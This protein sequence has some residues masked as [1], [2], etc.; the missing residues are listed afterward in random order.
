MPEKQKGQSLGIPAEG[1]ELR[2][3]GFA[4]DRERWTF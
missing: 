1:G 3:A 4:V 2:L